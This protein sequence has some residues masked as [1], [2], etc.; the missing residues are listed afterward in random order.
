MSKKNLIFVKI[1]FLL[2]LVI[3]LDAKDKSLNAI[4]TNDL[5]PRYGVSSSYDLINHFANFKKFVDVNNC[6]IGFSNILGNGI[7][8]GASYDLPRDYKSEYQI[9]VDYS[10][11]DGFFKANEE[12]P[13]I[14]DGNTVNG[15]FEHQL[16]TTI[17]Q[18]NLNPNYS[19]KPYL[20]KRLFLHAGLNFS[21][22]M[23]SYFSQKEV[24]IDPV[25]RG[26]FKEGGRER[27]Y[28]SGSIPSAV[29]FGAGIN[30]GASYELPMS[31]KKNLFLVPNVRFNYNFTNLADV[32]WNYS[33]LRIGL[34]VKYRTP[35]TPPPPPPPPS[36]PPFLD[37][38]PLPQ[39]P[40][41]LSV[42]MNIV[43]IDSNGN[44]NT[45]P[46][47]K[48]ED[49]VS[50]NMRPLLNYIFF[51]ENSSKLPNRYN[52][53]TRTEV[54]NF[55]LKDLQNYDALSTYYQVLNI[56]G[57]RLKDE[58]T[59]ITLIGCNANLRDEKGNKELSKNRALTVKEYLTNVWQVPEDDIK[60]EARNL[61]EDDS[62]SDTITSQQENMRVEITC[63]NE[64]I[65]K[66]VIT[67][68]TLRQINKTKF[69]FTPIVNSKLEI[70]KFN[71]SIKQGNNTLYTKSGEGKPP[72]N[73]EWTLEQDS[74]NITLNKNQPIIYS[75]Q[76]E[77]ELGNLADIGKPNIKLEQLTVEK[78]RLEKQDDKQ[79]EYYSLILFDY[80]KSSLGKEHKEVVDFVK[81]R[82]EDNAKV[83]IYGYT[84]AKGEPKINQRI[85]EERAKAVAKRLNLANAEVEGVGERSLLYDNYYPEGRFY[86]RTVR[87]LVEQDVKK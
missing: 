48:I 58:P 57:K 72:N 63:K 65:I 1:F 37:K 20:D 71:F 10:Y 52:L 34:G 68:D 27:N 43:E 45:N 46:Q 31:R 44:T 4:D 40:P 30:F 60:V 9:R 53:M 66:P 76:I 41:S 50:L 19:W 28:F 85:S 77:D 87:I 67:I 29:F 7:S 79:F 82:I 62:K 12:I 70:K 33:A 56:I 51:D 6:C 47:I 61:P 25:D 86:C 11:I 59:Q 54:N 35:A 5:K 38:L 64:N 3:N 36:F 55:K 84:D 26:T 23:S 83:F 32:T 24:V 49:F 18:I 78:K 73:F 16:F 14:I 13:V 15:K 39:S 22:L 69:Q 74:K 21:L 75:F 2:S 42:A 80:G 81:D 8:F 17:S